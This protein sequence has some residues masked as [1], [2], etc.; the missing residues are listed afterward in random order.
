MNCL[1]EKYKTYEEGLKGF[2]YKMQSQ[3]RDFGN[4]EPP[5][6][7]DKERWTRKFNYFWGLEDLKALPNWI[8]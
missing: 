3:E 5:T 7:E 6:E 1:R 8:Y 2:F 4:Y